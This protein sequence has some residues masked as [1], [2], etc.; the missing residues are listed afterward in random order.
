M[1]RETICLIGGGAAVGDAGTER[2]H[3]GEEEGVGQRSER[4][5]DHRSG[6]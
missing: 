5:R 3:K 6:D 4:S 1:P 2:K